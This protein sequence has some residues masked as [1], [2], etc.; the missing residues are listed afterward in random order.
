MRDFGTPHGTSSTSRRRMPS[1]SWHRCF[2][3]RTCSSSSSVPAS[4]RVWVLAT[5]TCAA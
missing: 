1:R 2:A 3:V 4:W 5:K